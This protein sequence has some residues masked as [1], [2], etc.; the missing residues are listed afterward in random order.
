MAAASSPSILWLPMIKLGDALSL[1][2]QALY[3][4]QAGMSR[5]VMPAMLA[6]CSLSSFVSSPLACLSMQRSERQIGG[7]RHNL[8]MMRSGALKA[9]LERLGAR[10][11][12]AQAPSATCRP[13]LTG[14]IML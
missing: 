5:H 10:M 4:A 11:A 1:V 12:A 13:H 7:G 3:E 9:L 2:Q 14:K 6:E 8:P